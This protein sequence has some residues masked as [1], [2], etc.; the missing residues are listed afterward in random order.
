[1]KF[2]PGDTFRSRRTGV[3]YKV[4]EAGYHFYDVLVIAIDPGMDGYTVGERTTV[5]NRD[6]SWYSLVRK[7]VVKP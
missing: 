5:S 2:K 6:E 7:E 1:M 4:L 3:T